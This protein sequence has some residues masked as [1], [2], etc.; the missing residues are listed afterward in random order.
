MSGARTERVPSGTKIVRIG[1]T[2]FVDPTTHDESYSLV[3]FEEN[4]VWY[5][6]TPRMVPLDPE[7]VPSLLKDAPFVA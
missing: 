1:A 6:H 4:G 5:H 3:A 2:F 7:L